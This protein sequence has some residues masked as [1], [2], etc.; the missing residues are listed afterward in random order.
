MNLTTPL[1]KYFTTQQK[2]GVLLPSLCFFLF[3][4]INSKN[5]QPDGPEIF[6]PGKVST[7]AV[8]YSF[9]LSER[10]NEAYFTRSAAPWG[11]Q[12]AKSTIYFTTFQKG[13]W[14]IPKIAPFSGKMNDSDPYL[15][16]DGKTLYFIS[17]RQPNDNRV[18]SAD[19]WKVERASTGTWGAPVH[20]GDEINSDFNEYS[21]RTDAKGNLYFASDRPGGFG[22][23]DL[24]VAY[25]KQSGWSPPVNLGPTINTAGGEWNLEISKDGNVLFFEA[26]GRPQNASS[27]GDLYLSFKLHGQWTSPQNLVSLNTSGSELAPEWREKTF[28]LY[29]AS[30]DSLSGKTTHI[31]AVDFKNEY[32]DYRKNALECTTPPRK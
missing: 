29:Y 2:I 11:T 15:S 23:G 10:G 20:L 27:F 26:S 3:S 30:S 7:K 32:L 4:C 9:S 6:E 31:Y 21:P 12:N 17:N 25:K 14:A 1:R 5:W 28:T 16:T 22:Q 13:Q 24:Y 18:A 19:I 8:E